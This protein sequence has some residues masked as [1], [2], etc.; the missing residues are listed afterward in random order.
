MP[1]YVTFFSYTAET[2]GRMIANPGDRTAAVRATAEAAGGSVE[3]LHWMLGAHDGMLI[4]DAP[5]SATA[6]AII[7]TVVSSGSFRATETHELFNQDQLTQMLGKA[8][9]ARSTYRAP[10][11]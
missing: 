3:S 6:A 7:T 9:T 11:T 5:D 8:S 2:W 10:G 4:M 1:K